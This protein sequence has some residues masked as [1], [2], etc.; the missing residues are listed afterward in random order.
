MGIGGLVGRV[1]GTVG[2]VV[3]GG[4]FPSNLLT[5][6]LGFLQNERTNRANTA[7]AN[8]QMAFQERM[9]NTAVTRRMQ[10]LRNAGINPIL[11]GQYDAS[12]PAGAMATHTNSAAAGAATAQAASQAQ[13]NT[14]T[15]PN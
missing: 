3:G 11:A 9:S 4:S 2:R 15:L 14:E 5:G 10:D 1:V 6:G 13:L 12:T 7:Q 8:N